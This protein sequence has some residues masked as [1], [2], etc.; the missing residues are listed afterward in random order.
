M[1]EN[2]IVDFSTLR[3]LRTIT[4]EEHIKDCGCRYCREI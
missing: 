1:N 3:D 4:P 2:I